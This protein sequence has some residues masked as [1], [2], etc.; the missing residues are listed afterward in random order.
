MRTTFDRMFSF[1]FGLLLVALVGFS[2]SSPLVAA[3]MRGLTPS[4]QPNTPTNTTVPPLPTPT[5]TPPPPPTATP[6][7]PTPTDTLPVPTPTVTP[8]PP[9]PTGTLPAPTPT[10]TPQPPTPTGTL[11]A[12]TPTATPTNSVTLTPSIPPIPTDT[13]RPTIPIIETDPDPLVTKRAGSDR[14]RVGEDLEFIL[15]VTNQGD[16]PALDVV[17][18]DPLPDFLAYVSSSTSRGTIAVE[19]NQIIITLGAVQHNEVIEIRIITRVLRIPSPPNNVN[20]VQLATSSR[21]DQPINNR[22]AVPINFIEPPL[23]ETP[24][25]PDVTAVPVQAPPPSGGIAFLPGSELPTPTLTPLPD[26][27]PVAVGITVQ[28]RLPPTGASDD[29]VWVL[30][31]AG[32]GLIAL[33]LLPRRFIRR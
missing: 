21:G 14:A 27:P 17:V 25:T 1:F 26:A 33:S 13:P 10:D 23:T 12:P 7:P 32:L 28:K 19:G 11:P 24:S 16:K 9:T 30:L 4:P 22:D 8:Q 2:H 5:N 20:T 15:T 31:V 18:V 29:S 3:P 6:L